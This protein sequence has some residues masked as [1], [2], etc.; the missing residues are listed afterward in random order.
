MARIPKGLAHL[1]PDDLTGRVVALSVRPRRR[2]PVRSVEAWDLDASSDH[3]RRGDRAVTLMA[4]EQLQASEALLG[5]PIDFA[6]TRRNVLIEGLNPALLRHTRFRI[7]DAV[8]EGTK[9]C[10][11]CSRMDETFGP[12]AWAAM[13]GHGGMCARIVTPGRIRVGDVVRLE[14]EDG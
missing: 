4:R 9:P 1:V 7:G 14:P 13:V 11:P 10:E 8:L 2:E 3:A 12:G 6:G 5:R